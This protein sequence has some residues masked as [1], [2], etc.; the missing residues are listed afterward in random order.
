MS[1]QNW[2]IN[3]IMNQQTIYMWKHNQSIYSPT[4]PVLP[5]PQRSSQLGIPNDPHLWTTSQVILTN[6]YS[7]ILLHTKPLTYGQPIKYFL[8]LTSYESHVKF[9]C[10][11]FSSPGVCLAPMGSSG[12]SGSL[13]QIL[14]PFAKILSNLELPKILI[15]GS[16]CNYIY[17]GSVAERLCEHFHPELQSVWTRPM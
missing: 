15:T 17:S 11:N 5:F 8:L 1:H 9:I 16:G 2:K 3:I 7:T 10:A 6:M 12:V 4:L 13:T 14:V